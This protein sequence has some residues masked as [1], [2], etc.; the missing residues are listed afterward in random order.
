[1][2]ISEIRY[3]RMIVAETYLTVLTELHDRGKDYMVSELLDIV[4]GHKVTEE[5]E[6]GTAADIEA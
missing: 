2:E 1:M 6:N 5:D 4:S 3:R